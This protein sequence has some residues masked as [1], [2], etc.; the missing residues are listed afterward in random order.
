MSFLDT[1]RSGIALARTLTDSLQTTVTQE[2]SAGQDLRGKQIYPTIVSQK[3]I[4]EMRQRAIKTSN[5]ESVIARASI[6]FLDPAVVVNYT[7]RLTLPNGYSG[8]ILEIEGF[9]DPGT[10]KPMLTQVY[11]G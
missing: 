8:P 7:D 2:V 3:A 5:G 11:L 1:L 4:V 6:L 9:M 10:Q